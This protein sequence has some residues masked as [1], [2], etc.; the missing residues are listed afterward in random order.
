MNEAQLFVTVV[1]SIF[2]LWGLVIVFFP[3]QSQHWWSGF[4]KEKWAEL[5]AVKELGTLEKH[6]EGLSFTQKIHYGYIIWGNKYRAVGL[7]IFLFDLLFI[8]V[9]INSDNW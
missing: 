3:S 5:E 7:L 8:L 2:A 6:V 4:S 9:A 1:L